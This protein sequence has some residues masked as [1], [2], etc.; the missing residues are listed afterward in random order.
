MAAQWHATTG[1][2]AADI[3]DVEAL[4]K[5]IEQKIIK[6]VEFDILVAFMFYPILSLANKRL[7]K[8]F[9]NN[10]ENIETAFVLAWDAIKL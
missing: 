3:Y 6:N 4:Q 7:C 2:A 10:E 1:I 5:G 8:H 9:V